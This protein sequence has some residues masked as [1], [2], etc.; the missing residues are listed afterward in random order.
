[1]ATIQTRYFGIV[2][3]DV[4]LPIEFPAGLPAFEKER[5]FLA[6]EHPRTAPL[7]FLQSAIKREL[8]FLALPVSIL[9]T[10]YRL[11]MSSDDMAL[12]G[13]DECDIGSREKLAVL[14]FV[15]VEPNGRVTANLMAP[16]VVNR[17]NRR[18]VQA[19]RCDGVY[20][21]DHPISLP[22]GAPAGEETLCS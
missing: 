19:V 5:R 7:V 20:A 13:I 14:A 9:D 4:G 11:Q 18:A 8:C 1:M 10:F 17:E 16:I 6:I 3:E 22:T 2:P 12:I 15:V 21:H